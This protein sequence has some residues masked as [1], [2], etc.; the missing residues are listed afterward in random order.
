MIATNTE[1][2]LLE[3]LKMVSYCSLN[4]AKRLKPELDFYTKSELN[5]LAQ[6]LEAAGMIK[7]FPRASQ[8]RR[9]LETVYIVTVSGTE[10]LKA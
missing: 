7:E 5:S 10:W 3:A 4:T 1:K 9:A 6:S 2:V 8:Y